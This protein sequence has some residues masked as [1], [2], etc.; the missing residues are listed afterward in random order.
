[1]GF[2]GLCLL[3]GVAE[4][5]LAAS[6][7]GNWYLSLTP[8]PGTPPNWVF[9]PV[10]GTLYVLVGV[11]AWLVWR[12]IGA[13]P[14]LTLW[15]WQLLVNAFWAPAFFGL[16]STAGGLLVLLVLTPLI[17]LTLRTFYGVDR[18]AAALMLPYA[19]ST[20]YATYLAAGFWWLN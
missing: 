3:V 14:P 17:L 7:L 16:H 20:A 11:A 8:P 18:V 1:V 9:A 13:A 5:E 10:C 6:G 15:G 19:A 2:V 4:G 12:R